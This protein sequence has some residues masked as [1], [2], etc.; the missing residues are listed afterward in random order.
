M[1]AFMYKVLRNTLI[2][3]VNDNRGTFGSLMDGNSTKD[4]G[5]FANPMLVITHIL[6][7]K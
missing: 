5:L 2:S 4:H 1:H 3:I 7:Y 6:L